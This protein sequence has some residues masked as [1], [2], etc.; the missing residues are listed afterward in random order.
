MHLNRMFQVQIIFKL[1]CFTAVSVTESS[2]CYGFY[3]LTF[4]YQWF[5][6]FIYIFKSNLIIYAL[7]EGEWHAKEIR[8]HTF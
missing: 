8:M 2:T 3:K 7:V 5:T 1:W 4:K 6:F